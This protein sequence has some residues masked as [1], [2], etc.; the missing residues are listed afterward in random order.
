V[1]SFLDRVHK[2]RGKSGWP[3]SKWQADL[4]EHWE[5]DT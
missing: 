3:E 4:V 1:V 2:A 5:V